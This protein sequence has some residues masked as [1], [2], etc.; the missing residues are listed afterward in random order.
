MLKK[1]RNVFGLRASQ[2]AVFGRG[3]MAS[4]VYTRTPASDI[5]L[6]VGDTIRGRLKTDRDS[7]GDPK[8]QCGIC[9]G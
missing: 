2:G 9:G 1:I 8:T 5:V 3:H 7:G 4:N 6:H